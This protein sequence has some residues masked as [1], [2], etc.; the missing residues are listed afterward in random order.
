MSS[1]L[2]S[3][4][5]L[6]RPL[7]STVDYGN[8]PEDFAASSAL[9][10]RP[11]LHLFAAHMCLA[12]IHNGGLLQLFWNTTGILVPEGVEGF[13]VVKM[14]NMALLLEQAALLLG[15]T[16]PRDRDERWDALLTA[17]GRKPK[18]LE[19]V[20]KK[21]ENFYLGFAEATAN[22]SFDWLNK[23]LWELAET[24]HGGFQDAA[25]EYA[26]GLQLFQ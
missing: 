19:K 8:G 26:N 5:E 24:E 6:V 22:L 10:P 12:E 2:N 17:S 21:A 11:H 23:K 20:F 18:D 13:R 16:Y 25:T 9:I 3:Y 15:A 4:W 1:T 7:I 14:P